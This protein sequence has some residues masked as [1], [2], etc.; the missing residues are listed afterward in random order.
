M[1]Q[2]T[3][4]IESVKYIAIRENLAFLLG[5]VLTSTRPA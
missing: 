3:V 4:D 5:Y 2:Q 1:S